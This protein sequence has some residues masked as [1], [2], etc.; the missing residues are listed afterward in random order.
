MKDGYDAERQEGFKQK[1]IAKA[2]SSYNKQ[3]LECDAE[4]DSPNPRSD[5]YFI[6]VVVESSRK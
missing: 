4:S 3:K 2:Q 1:R 5:G 6:F